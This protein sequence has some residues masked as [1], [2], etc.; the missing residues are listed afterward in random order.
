M[1][2]T[3][4]NFN[5]TSDSCKTQFKKYNFANFSPKYMFECNPISVKKF[6]GLFTKVYGYIA[7]SKTWHILILK[8]EKVHRFL[9]A[10]DHG[11]AL[12][13]VF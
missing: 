1:T 2:N 4:E 6:E 11:G 13:V 8:V 5:P 7:I 9:P 12:L 3:I 10:G